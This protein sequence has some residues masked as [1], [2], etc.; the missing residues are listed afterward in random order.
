[1]A[2]NRM[3]HSEVIHYDWVIKGGF[4]L[5]VLETY[6]Y[7]FAPENWTPCLFNDREENFPTLSSDDF[8]YTWQR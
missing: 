8:L 5:V 6:R 3:P 2:A 1:M 4:R 7:M